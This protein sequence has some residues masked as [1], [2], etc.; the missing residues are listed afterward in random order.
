MKKLKKRLSTPVIILLL[1]TLVVLVTILSLKYMTFVAAPLLFAFVIAYLF[2]PVVNR[3][4]KKTRLPRGLIAAGLMSLLILVLVILVA[5][6]IPYAVDQIS[7][8]VE[9]LPQILADFTAQVKEFSKY[10]S[11][12]F[13]DYVGNIDLMGRIKDIVYRILYNFSNVLLDLFSRLY[14]LILMVFYLVIT[15]LFA[16]YFLK[17]YRKIKDAILGLVPDRLRGRVIGKAKKMNHL[18]SSF[19]RGQAIVVVILAILYSIGLTLVGLPFS[20]LIGIGAGLGDIIPYLGTVVGLIVSL[21]IGLAHFQSAEKLLLILLIFAIIK[22]SENWYFYPKIV[23]KEVGLHF[24]WVL[25]SIIVFGNIFGFWG[26]LVAIPASA[27]FKMFIS[28][29]IKYY[30]KTEFFNRS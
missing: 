19:I 10:I 26:L 3:L 14:T 17:D 8:A 27:G 11:R 21:V 30:K 5:N 23:G 18:L 29:V 13:S 15:P 9:K 24:V 16:F 12:N 1:Y 7:N 6:L 4:E 25:L 28:D 22:G 2:N 20:I